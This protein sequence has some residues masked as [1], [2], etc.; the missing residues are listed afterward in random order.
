MAGAVRAPHFDVDTLAGPAHTL[1][2]YF[3]NTSNSLLLPSSLL[4]TFDFISL[5]PPLTGF[6]SLVL[7][8]TAFPVLLAGY[9]GSW[10]HR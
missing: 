7:F 4:G 3:Y 1:I 9:T 2:Y 10:R 8:F 5:L 6:R